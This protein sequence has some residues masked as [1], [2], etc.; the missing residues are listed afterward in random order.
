MSMESISEMYHDENIV[1]NC[2]GGT[3]GRSFQFV[4]S[5]RT[6]LTSLKMH[7]HRG[8]DVTYTCQIH[9]SLP[10]NNSSRRELFCPRLKIYRRHRLWS[11]NAIAN[12]EC[13]ERR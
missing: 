3:A 1:G 11:E 9:G 4:S 10:W 7:P 2:Y 5:W 13:S 12:K 6:C 8:G